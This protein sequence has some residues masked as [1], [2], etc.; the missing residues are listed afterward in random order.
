ML[1]LKIKEAEKVDY[2]ICK[3]CGRKLKSKASRELGYGPSCF[4]REMNNKGL[5]ILKLWGDELEQ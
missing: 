4:N 3:R 5:A 2:E 1:N